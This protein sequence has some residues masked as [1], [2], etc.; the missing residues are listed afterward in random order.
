MSITL[1]SSQLSVARNRD[2]RETY[3][4]M[5]FQEKSPYAKDRP[6]EREGRE[7]RESRDKQYPFLYI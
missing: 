4:R 1:P 2:I 7:G 6:H 5:Y 3:A